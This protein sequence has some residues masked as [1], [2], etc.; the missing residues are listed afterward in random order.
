MGSGHFKITI[1]TDKYEEKMILGLA[2]RNK[3]I[4]LKTR[5]VAVGLYVVENAYEGRYEYFESDDVPTTE[6]KLDSNQP[7]PTTN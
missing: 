2:Y 3:D 6:T 7:E 5:K 1:L 4:L